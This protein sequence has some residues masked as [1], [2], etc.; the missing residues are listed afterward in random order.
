MEIF[1]C[2]E[3]G[4]LNRVGAAR[5]GQAMCGR[6][7]SALDTSGAPQEVDAAGLRAAIASAPVPVLLDLWAPWCGP[8]RQAAPILERIARARAGRLLVLKLNTE[9]H[10]EGA[11]PLGIQG[12]PTFVIFAGGSEQARQVGL[13]SPEA[14]ARWIDARLEGGAAAHP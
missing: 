6:C 4:Q 11:A 1:R 12:I 10:P 7:R 13:P 2:G 9:Q 5:E 3:C 8:C 14:L